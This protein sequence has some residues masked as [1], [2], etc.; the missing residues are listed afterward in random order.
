MN[1]KKAGRLAKC[2]SK[3]S[4]TNTEKQKVGGASKG[5][6]EGRGSQCWEGVQSFQQEGEKVLDG[7]VNALITSDLTATR[8][9]DGQFHVLCFS[10]Q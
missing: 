3:G 5:W 7:S 4:I 2:H 9:Q 8:G 1:N 10:P 6:G